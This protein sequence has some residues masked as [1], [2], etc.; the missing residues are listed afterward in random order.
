MKKN[1][2]SGKAFVKDA[3]KSNKLLTDFLLT[4]IL[5]MVAFDFTTLIGIILFILYFTVLAF[6]SIRNNNVYTNILFEICK[7]KLYTC[8]F[9]CKI[10]AEDVIIA[11]CIAISKINLVQKIESEVSYFDFDNDIF[12]IL[13]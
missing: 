4:Y 10:I 12:L 1:E 2:K 11:D 7:Y 5:P 8:Q 3:K 13:K 6:V 9:V